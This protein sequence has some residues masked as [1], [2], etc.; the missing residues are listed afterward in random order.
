MAKQFNF[1]SLDSTT[2]TLTFYSPS[3][4]AVQATNQFN[5]RKLDYVLAQSP[6]TVVFTANSG[7]SSSF[8]FNMTE[9]V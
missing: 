7:S 8:F 4:A 2:S 6:I 3:G 5:E 9:K 1:T